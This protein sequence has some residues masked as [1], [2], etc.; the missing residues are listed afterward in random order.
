MKVNKVLTGLLFICMACRPSLDKPAYIA[1]VTDYEHGLHV[2]R[3]LSG[4]T[5]DVQYQPYDML[6]LQGMTEPD[7]LQHILLSILPPGPSGDL[8]QYGA[9]NEETWQQ[10]MYYF[11]YSFQQ[12]IYLE[13]GTRRLPCVLYHFEETARQGKGKTFVLAFENPD[14]SLA[15]PCRLVIESPF[16]G[17]VPVKIPISKSDIPKLVI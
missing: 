13:Q 7:S 17:V 11:S 9:D 8:V 14:P 4:Y 3:S 1:W 15:A 12:D 5:F 2:R 10:R 6:R 16:M